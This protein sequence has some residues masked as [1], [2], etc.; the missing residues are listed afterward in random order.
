MAN[1]LVIEH[2]APEPAWA[3][4]RLARS[5]RYPNQAF[6]VGES[7]RGLQFQLEVTPA[8]VE[9]LLREFAADAARAP[10]GHRRFSRATARPLE[11]LNPVVTWSPTGSPPWSPPEPVRR[12]PMDLVTVS[13]VFLDREL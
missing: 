8:A 13:R 10:G 4:G 1:C 2:A 6:R 9:G 12:H 5:V 11:I 3:R 7:A